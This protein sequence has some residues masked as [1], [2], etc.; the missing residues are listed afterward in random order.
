LLF[1]KLIIIH[2][3]SNDLVIFG[4]RGGNHREKIWYKEE[5]EVVLSLKNLVHH[6]ALS[7][8]SCCKPSSQVPVAPSPEIS[9]QHLHFFLASLELVF[10]L[11][12]SIFLPIHFTPN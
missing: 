4:R 10:L 2:V 3:N 8:S 12:G 7:A 1:F 5:L 6:V 11:K 9:H